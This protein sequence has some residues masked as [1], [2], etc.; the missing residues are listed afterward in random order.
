MDLIGGLDLLSGRDLA[1]LGLLA[2]CWFG[3]GWLIEHPVGKSRSV[4]LLM[5]EYRNDWLRE[6]PTRQPRIFDATIISI[7]RQGTTFFASSCMIAIG[8]GLALIGNTKPLSDVASDLVQ[9]QTP[10]V[11]WEIKILLVIIFLASAFLRFVWAHR[12]F[13]YAAILMA[14]VPNDT[15]DPITYPRAQKA[16][17]VTTLG[18]RSFNRGMRSVYF[19]LGAVSWFLGAVPL[20][21][22]TIAVTAMIWRREFA[23]H[24]R[25]VL[26]RDDHP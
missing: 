17:D 26:L 21:F 9:N 18:A 22:G 16:A 3:I 2:I 19:A 25:D 10:Q 15:E 20:A 4:S 23:S 12:L 5:H 8:G 24:S 7:L 13:G 1:A 6:Y 11:V 14:S